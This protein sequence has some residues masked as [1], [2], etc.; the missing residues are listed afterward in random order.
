M[1]RLGRLSLALA[2]AILGASLAQGDSNLQATLERKIVVT[3]NKTI[4]TLFCLLNLGGYDEEN[5]PAGMHPVRIQVRQQLARVV[6]PDVATR[7]HSFHQDHKNAEPF[8]YSVVAMLTSGPPD[9]KFTAEWSDVRKDPSFG[10]LE[11]LPPLLHDLYATSPIE[12]IYAQV[13][14]DYQRYIGQYRVAIV[15]QVSKVMAY[16]RVSKLTDVS[17][18]EVQHADIIP[19]LLDSFDNAF[20]FVLSDT[21]YSVEGPHERI[22][23]NPHEFVHSITNSMSYDPR[24]KT[25]QEPARSLYDVARTIS[26]IGDVAS[27]QNFLDENLVRAI[28]LKYLDDGTP[29]RSAQLRE[30]MM[31]EYRSG[32]ILERFF[33]EQLDEYEKSGQG[34]GTYYPI[35]LK[36]LD[37]NYELAR[38]KAETKALSK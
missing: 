25:L 10:S 4:F 16:C 31:Q 8:N 27:L 6:P 5:N 29:A 7:I 20:S 24:Y 2:A 11:S 38:W 13:R 19:N 12:K 9:F 34:L 3:E 21:F 28:S 33:Y 37:A 15:T 18:G 1:T 22:G 35:M 26:G 32:Y 17:S 14:P 36:R 23:Y 30:L